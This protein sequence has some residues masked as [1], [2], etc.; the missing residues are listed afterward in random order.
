MIQG[1]EDRITESSVVP[2]QT[3]GNKLPLFFC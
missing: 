3:Q 2:I 1:S